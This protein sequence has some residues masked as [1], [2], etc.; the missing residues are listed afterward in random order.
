MINQNIEFNFSDAVSQWQASRC[1]SVVFGTFYKKT[2][3]KI[4]VL[5]QCTPEVDNQLSIFFQFSEPLTDN[6]LKYLHN[7]IENYDI[8]SNNMLTIEKLSNYDL[9][10]DLDFKLKEESQQIKKELFS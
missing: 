2:G 8:L 3:K 4:T 7:L 5:F 1:F 9:T 6:E 10:K